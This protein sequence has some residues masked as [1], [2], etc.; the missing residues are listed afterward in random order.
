M[1]FTT[2]F[3]G[4]SISPETN[5][6]L[7]HATLENTE[8]TIAA[9]IPPKS[10]IPEIDMH[11]TDGSRK[12]A[13]ESAEH[14]H[15]NGDDHSHDQNVVS[16]PSSGQNSMGM[17]SKMRIISADEIIERNKISKE[18]ADKFGYLLVQNFEGRIV[19]MVITIGLDFGFFPM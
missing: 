11:G 8:P 10:V 6:T 4:F 3:F 15:T 2:F 17:N 19:P 14:I 18:H 13:T 7:S 12:A 5:V 9:A 16:E 1:D